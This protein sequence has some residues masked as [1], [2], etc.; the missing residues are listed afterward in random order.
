MYVGKILIV[1]GYKSLSPPSSLKAA[2]LPVTLHRLLDAYTS[3][4]LILT[5]TMAKIH[6]PADS[7]LFTNGISAITMYCI[8]FNNY[9]I[10]LCG[11]ALIYLTSHLMMKT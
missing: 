7:L 9:Y 5:D 1:Q 6:C 3:N 11:Y 10:P 2:I 8:L 4:S